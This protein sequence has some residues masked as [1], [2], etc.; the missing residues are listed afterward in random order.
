[1]LKTSRKI[2]AASGID[3]LLAGAPQPVEVEQRVEAEDAQA[4]DRVD[5]RAA[6][7]VHE[8]QDDPEDDQAEQQPEREPVEARQVAPDRVAARAERRDEEPG[9]GRRLVERARVVR[10]VVVEHVADGDP[11]QQAEGEQQHERELAVAAGVGDVQPEDAAERDEP[12]HED[13]SG[14]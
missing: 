10:R 13:R 9:R 3:L 12:R 1:M 5:Q 2:P 7:H 14:R 8:D 11:E 4:E 6:R